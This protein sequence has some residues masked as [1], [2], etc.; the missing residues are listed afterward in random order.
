MSNTIRVSRKFFAS[1]LLALLSSAKLL[2]PVRCSRCPDQCPPGCGA[3]RPDCDNIYCVASR[4]LENPVPAV[5][6]ASIIAG[7]GALIGM[8]AK[9]E[10][11][12]LSKLGEMGV[13]EFGESYDR[14]FSLLGQSFETHKTSNFKFDASTRSKSGGHK[15]ASDDGAPGSGFNKNNDYENDGFRRNDHAGS[16]RNEDYNGRSN[17][18]DSYGMH[19]S[20]MGVDHDL[21]VINGSDESSSDESDQEAENQTSSRAVKGTDSINTRQ[22][23]AGWGCT[24]M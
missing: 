20:A 23:V 16:Q 3:P 4:A 8:P 22:E 13:S 12:R 9:S 7:A 14:H 24:M 2:E 19:K 5:L 10:N 11:E 18:D 17:Q 1:T 15:K 6:G 21:L